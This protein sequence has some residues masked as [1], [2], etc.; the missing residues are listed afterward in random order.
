[1]TS[2]SRKR[3]ILTTAADWIS[4]IPHTESLNRNQAEQSQTEVR[5]NGLMTF[6]SKKEAMGQFLNAILTDFLE[7]RA[8]LDARKGL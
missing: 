1:M 2:A 8:L 5:N 4:T 3:E 7:I 6:A